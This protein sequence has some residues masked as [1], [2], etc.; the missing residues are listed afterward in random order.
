M[1]HH[2]PYC[3]GTVVLWAII[4]VLLATFCNEVHIFFAVSH[5]S[6]LGCFARTT[7]TEDHWTGKSRAIID[8]R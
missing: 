3:T 8:N 7:I 2:H 1:S 5:S 4:A 6:F